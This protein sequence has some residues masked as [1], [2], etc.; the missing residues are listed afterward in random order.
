MRKRKA[1]PLSDLVN[2]TLTPEEALRLM[3]EVERNPEVS[4]QLD[5]QVEL[6]NLARSPGE[7]VF[8]I[9]RAPES[10]I[11]RILRG[12]VSN[13][14]LVLATRRTFAAVGV[15]LAFVLVGAAVLTI[16]SVEAN[17]YARLA[18]VRGADLPFR[19]R[20]ESDV[21]LVAATELVADRDYGAAAQRFERFL[22]MYPTG[23]SVP[24]VEYAAGVVRLAAARKSVWGFVQSYDSKEVDAGIQHLQ[25]VVD[26]RTVP[27]LREDALWYQAK[28]YLML[29]RV[30]DAEQTLQRL[31]LLGGGRSSAATSML[32]EIQRIHQ[33]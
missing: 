30:T 7:E 5:F 32:G 33:R 16:R 19:A 26:G 15:C 3:D 29:G 12:I 4:R 22:R 18:E 27:A 11:G 9:S 31:V 25:R 21:D 14:G 20:S 23:E 8:R 17:P 28:G 2:G 10:A 24:W 6:L 1:P 13:L